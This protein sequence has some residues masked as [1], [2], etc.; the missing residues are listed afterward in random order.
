MSKCGDASACSVLYFWGQGHKQ[1]PFT[2]LRVQSHVYFMAES[3]WLPMQ[4][5]DI[6]ECL[7]VIF[8][9]LVL[10]SFFDGSIPPQSST[11]LFSHAASSQFVFWFGWFK[12]RY[13]V[14]GLEHF[15]FFHMLGII[16]P[17]DYFSEGVKPPTS[18]S[19]QTL[20]K[21]ISPRIL[22]ERHSCRFFVFIEVTS[23]IS[24]KYAVHFEM[25]F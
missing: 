19:P 6:E 21:T 17:T 7:C 25:P 8:G 11:N 12:Q 1:F 18:Y 3:C 14:G 20:E 16:I 15:L 22:S 24:R 4:L 23:T 5:M 13:L 10:S 2:S 9:G